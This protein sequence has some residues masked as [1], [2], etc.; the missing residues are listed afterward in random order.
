MDKF[1]RL[2]NAVVKGDKSG[3]INSIHDFSEEDIIGLTE[4]EF[5]EILRCCAEMKLGRLKKFF[6]LR[7]KQKKS[8]EKSRVKQL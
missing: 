2:R 6:D 8:Y 1:D 3:F 4:Q 5:E 7:K